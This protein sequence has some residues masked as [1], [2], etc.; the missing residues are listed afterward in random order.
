MFKKMVNDYLD[1]RYITTDNL[2]E[3][4]INALQKLAD[5][6]RTHFANAVDSALNDWATSNSKKK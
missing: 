5:D 6:Q 4:T 3:T 2:P 1:G